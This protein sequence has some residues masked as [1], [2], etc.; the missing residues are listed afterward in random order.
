[1]EAQAPLA[2]RG[3]DLT[4]L[5]AAWQRWLASK[6]P[7]ESGTVQTYR[8]VLNEAMPLLAAI[9]RESGGVLTPVEVRA[10]ADRLAHGERPHKP[11]TVALHLAVLSSFWSHLQAEGIVRENPWRLVQRRGV[12][13]TFAERILTQ[14]EIHRLIQAARP[15]R[16]RLLLRFLYLTGARVGEACA[17]RWRDIAR[18]GSRWVVTLFGKGEKTRWV[19]LPDYFVE[20]LRAYSGQS[21]PDAPLWPT[22][23]RSARNAAR[24]GAIAPRTAEHIVERTALRAGMARQFWDPKARKLVIRWERRPSPHWLRHSHASHAL[25]KGAPIHYVQHTLGHASLA[26]TGLYAHALGGESSVAYLEDPGREASS[27]A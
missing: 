16:D 14:E 20:E 12:K 1:M 3:P 9:L 17:V 21:G 13:R 4:Q 19:P 15:G 26:T 24:Q 8:R 5:Q 7:P 6:G 2:L 10:Y 27:Q 18:Q 25:A 11:A 22:R 23:Y